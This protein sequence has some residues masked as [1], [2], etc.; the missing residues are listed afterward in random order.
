MQLDDDP[1]AGPGGR[2]D[3]AWLGAACYAVMNCQSRLAEPVPELTAE[4]ATPPL[5]PMTEA[6]P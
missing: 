6:P 2:S 5:R 4:A 1:L 3:G